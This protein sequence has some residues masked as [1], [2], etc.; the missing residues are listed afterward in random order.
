M[1]RD[2]QCQGCGLGV[3]GEMTPAVRLDRVEV[4][5]GSPVQLSLFRGDMPLPV[6]E[7]GIFTCFGI[8]PRS[9]IKENPKKMRQW[10]VIIGL[11]LLRS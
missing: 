3:T 8:R 2:A 5:C 6:A 1:C 10:S 4:A 11:K 9:K 7:Y